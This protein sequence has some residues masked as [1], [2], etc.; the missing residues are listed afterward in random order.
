MQLNVTVAQNI[1]MLQ[2][3]NVNPVILKLMVYVKLVLIIV[4]LVLELEPIVSLVPVI[5]SIHNSV[6]VQMENMMMVLK[7]LNVKHVLI[8][9]LDVNTLIITVPFVPLTDLV[10]QNVNVNTE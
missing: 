9:V 10:S 1:E 7:M 6:V 2:L 8:N 5:E 4:P 3:V